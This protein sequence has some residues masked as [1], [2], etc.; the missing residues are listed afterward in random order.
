MKEGNRKWFKAC[1]SSMYVVFPYWNQWQLWC[2]GGLTQR[3]KKISKVLWKGKK[4]AESFKHATDLKK[5]SHKYTCLTLKFFQAVLLKNGCFNLLW[6]NH[7]DGSCK[8]FCYLNFYLALSHWCIFHRSKAEL[9]VATWDK[10]F[11]SSEMAQ[12]VPLLY[13]ANDILQNSKRKG[14]EFVSEFWKVLPAALKAVVE[15]GDDHGK[16]VVSRL[17]WK[18][19][20]FYQFRFLNSLLFY[21]L[22]C[23]SFFCE[24]CQDG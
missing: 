5:G 1:M 22:L 16:N 7:M 11:H 14:N 15:K 10:Q 21:M 24:L 8:I 6:N 9:V 19:L 2:V 23:I 13:L 17:V 12:K 4:T 20:F 3:G 18:M